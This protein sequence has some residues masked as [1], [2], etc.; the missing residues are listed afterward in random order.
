MNNV[1]KKLKNNKYFLKNCKPLFSVLA[2][3]MEARSVKLLL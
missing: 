2:N 1:K 3:E